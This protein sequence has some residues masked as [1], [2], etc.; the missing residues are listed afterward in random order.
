MLF[1][2]VRILGLGIQLKSLNQYGEVFYVLDH[3]FYTTVCKKVA[4]KP[5]CEACTKNW[6]STTS[7]FCFLQ[8][9]FRRAD[10]PMRVSVETARKRRNKNTSPKPFW[11]FCKNFSHDLSE[12]IGFI[13]RGNPPEQRMAEVFPHKWSILTQIWFPH[14][15]LQGNNP[16]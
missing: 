5:P 8:L 2:A 16:L 3:W 10:W 14:R 1:D 9:F 13:K 7:L 4:S 6:V 12:N 15:R 11:L